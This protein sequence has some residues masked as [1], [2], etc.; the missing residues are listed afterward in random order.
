MKFKRTSITSGYEHL[1]FG[2]L[3]D[4]IIPE[5]WSTSSSTAETTVKTSLKEL[6]FNSYITVI[7]VYY[8]PDMRIVKK[9][10]E[11]FESSLYFSR[12]SF[13]FE[14][15]IKNP[16]TRYW[17]T[18]KLSLE[19]AHESRCPYLIFIFDFF[20]QPWRS[21]LKRSVLTKKIC[22]QVRMLES[23]WGKITW[24]GIWTLCACITFIVF[25]VYRIFQIRRRNFSYKILSRQY[26]FENGTYVNVNSRG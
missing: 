7:S 25:K 4:A 1:T 8:R 17:R 5:V 16:R 15:G 9:Q 11:N 6:I 18:F 13:Q 23:K 22:C 12:M 19:E 26:I 3:N 10:Q 24:T 21:I 2:C 20:L 14:C